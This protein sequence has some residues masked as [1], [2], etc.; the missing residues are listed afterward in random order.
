MCVTWF[1]DTCDM[2][3]WYV[4]HDS[5]MYEWVMR[6]ESVLLSH[7][8]MRHVTHMN[9]SCDTY[10]WVMSHI[11]KHYHMNGSCDRRERR[12]VRWGLRE[13]VSVQA[14]S[15]MIHVTRINESCHTYQWI[16]SHTSMS[17]VTHMNESCHM[18]DMTHSYVWHDSFMC[19][20]WLIHM[21]DMTHWYVW[22]DSFRTLPELKSPPVTPN[23]RL[24]FH[25]CHMTHSYDTAFTCVTWLI[26]MCHMTHSYVWHDSLICVTW[27]IRMRD[28][29]HSYVRHDFLDTAMRHIK[30]TRMDRPCHTYGW[31]M[32]HVGKSPGTHM[33]ESSHVWNR[34]IT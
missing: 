22:H 25:V 23:V 14:V 19:V 30:V 6:G 29:T 33:N 17:H 8:W 3:H 24:A 2:T 12:V 28:M 1:I 13:G 11:W 20:T 34:L 26:P 9:E 15:W 18:C 16:M 31:V 10:E 27:L 32:S 4:W 7:M 21:C 5:F